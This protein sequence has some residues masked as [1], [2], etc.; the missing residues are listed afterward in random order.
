MIFIPNFLMNELIKNLR[1][2]AVV[3][4]MTS[5]SSPTDATS[6]AVIFVF[7]V[8]ILAILYRMH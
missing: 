7:G 1:D 5:T 2:R 3:R 8:I 4:R 6:I